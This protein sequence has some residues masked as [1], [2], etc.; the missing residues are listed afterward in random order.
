VK[1]TTGQVLQNYINGRWVES[2]AELFEEI[3]NP[4][5]GERLARVPLDVWATVELTTDPELAA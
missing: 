4:A 1:L 3:P 5:T 2:Q